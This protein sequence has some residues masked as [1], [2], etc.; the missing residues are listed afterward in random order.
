MRNYSASTKNLFLFFSLNLSLVLHSSSQIINSPSVTHINGL[1]GEPA[2]NGA[3]NTTNEVISQTNFTGFN[4]SS[5]A[6][7]TVDNLN[8]ASS[9]VTYLVPSTTETGYISG[10]NSFDDIAKA[11]EFPAP[12]G[13]V[14]IQSAIILFAKA[15]AGST[16]S[17]VDVK[18]W[19]DKGGEPGVVLAT[20]TVKLSS[21]TVQKPFLVNFS[22]PPTV[23]GKYYIGVEWDSNSSQVDTIAIFTIE[24]DSTKIGTCWELWMDGFWISYY[25]SWNINVSHAIWSVECPET[26][27]SIEEANKNVFSVFPNP[28]SG[29]FSIS[30]DDLANS[31]ISIFDLLGNA[32][33]MEIKNVNNIF[34]VDF[35]KEARGVYII[36]VEKNGKEF[37]N[38][39]VVAD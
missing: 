10:T 35:N 34:E 12:K 2:L 25:D 33:I 37:N 1:R 7:D 15:Y 11:E 18:V 6:C 19:K 27:T 13:S 36:R 28:T 20:E 16:T 17:S 29:K 32:I 3:Y 38:K 39:I 9:L 26:T 14:I 21:I 8:N 4:S 31:K 5:A 22:S 24:H 30:G 23:T